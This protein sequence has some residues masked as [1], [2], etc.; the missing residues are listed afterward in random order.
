MS[1]VAQQHRTHVLDRSLWDALKAAVSQWVAHKDSKA[2]AAIAYYSIFSIGPLIV[3]AISIA[4][5]LFEREDVQE[6]VI[7]SLRGLIGDA[8]AGSIA[9]MLNGAGSQDEGLFAVIIGTVA[10]LYAAISVV[11]QLKEALNSVWEVKALTSSGLWS[12]VRS[13]VLSLAAV[14][15]LGFL[16]LTSMLLTAGLAAFSKYIGTFLPEALLQGAGFIVSFSVIS[17]LFALI[18]KWLP[19]ADIAWRDVWVGAVGTAV[20]FEIGKYLISFYIG[21]QGLESK[22]GAAASIVVVLIW[23]YYSAQIVLLGAEFTKAHR[24]QRISRDQRS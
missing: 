11:M 5:L 6:E 2:G 23:V 14:L 1:T 17:L 12:F 3:V 19:D 8:G 18:F 13:Y 15:A 9:T 22:Y 16:L 21:K 24:T 10:L 7:D 20:L 4:S